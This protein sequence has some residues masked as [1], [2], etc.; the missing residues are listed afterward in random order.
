MQNQKKADR[1]KRFQEVL[2]GLLGLGRF[3]LSELK[4]TFPK[5]SQSFVRRVVHDLERE[6]HLKRNDGES[7]CWTCKADDFPLQT[8]L[9]RKVYAPQITQTPAADRPR[10]RLLALG[11][12][13]LRTAELLAIL[14][15][16]GRTG[17]SALQAGEKIASR[18]SEELHRLAEA[19]RGDMNRVTGAV[20]ETAYC[21]IMAGIE[22]GRRVAQVQQDRGRV[23]HSIRDSAEALVFCRERFA[24]L[25]AEGKQEEFHVVCLDTK[26]QVVGVHRVSIGS[27]D[28]SLIHPRDVFRP[29]I[30]DAA[31]SILLVHNHPS[32]DP[33]P[34]DEDFLLTR[35]LE[36]VGKMVGILVLDHIIVARSGTTSIQE[37][38]AK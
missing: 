11:P 25:A 28:R 2:S 1:K 21:Q 19:G 24:R 4:T 35:R 33:T 36:E 32:G 26:N 15:R 10:E 12:A 29:A 7:F 17:E 30:Q 9:E 14:I 16:S 27:L 31:K 6:G 8:W 18:Y 23:A 20:G 34:S 13:A 38:G 22:L 37:F 5:E 3:T